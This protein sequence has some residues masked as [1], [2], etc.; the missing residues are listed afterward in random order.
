MSLLP[1]AKNRV[2]AVMLGTIIAVASIEVVLSC[3]SFDDDCISG[4]LLIV[5]NS[6]EV[7]V[8]EGR[9][10]LLTEEGVGTRL[11][12]VT[13]GV[14]RRLLLVEEGIGLLG[15]GESM[16][17]VDDGGGDDGESELPDIVEYNGETSVVGVTDGRS[18]NV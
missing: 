16:L 2:E 14:G 12:L 10:L 1:V 17:T 5:E 7:G 13:E 11:L 9:R 8:L 3:K 18:S 15:E 6:N 4:L